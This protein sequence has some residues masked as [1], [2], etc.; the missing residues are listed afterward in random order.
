V[1][2]G[3]S[4]DME[5]KPNPRSKS[6]KIQKSSSVI[7]PKFTDSKLGGSNNR[8]LKKNTSKSVNIIKT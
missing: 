3:D 7:T 5:F 1:S 6:V 4:L 2:K 8:M